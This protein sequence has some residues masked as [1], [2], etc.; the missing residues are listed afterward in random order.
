MTSTLSRH[1]RPLAALATVALIGAGCSNEPAENGGS[2]NA[3]ADY[4]NA[5]KFSECMRDN[6]VAGFPDPDASGELTVD[7]VVNGSS[8]DPSSSA[9]ENAIAACRDLQ[10]RGFTGDENVTDEEQEARLEFAQC[11]RDN[12]VEDFP[13]PAKDQPLVDTRRIPSAAQPGG[14]SILNAAMRACGDHAAQAGVT[15]P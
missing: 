15:G 1:L 8:I 10:P 13:D 3:N 6:G 5:V 9:W 4:E 12:G 14:M 11:M 2:G 7:G